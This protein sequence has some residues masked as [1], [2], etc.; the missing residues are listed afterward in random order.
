MLSLRKK[1]AKMPKRLSYDEY[2]ALHKEDE[3][4]SSSSSSSSPAPKRPKKSASPAASCVVIK[5]SQEELFGEMS[6]DSE[7]KVKIVKMTSPKGKSK[8]TKKT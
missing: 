5:A 6:S 7:G 1:I 8:A 4:S 2:M 3:S